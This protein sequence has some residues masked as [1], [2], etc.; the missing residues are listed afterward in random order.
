MVGRSRDRHRLRGAHRKAL[1][2]DLTKIGLAFVA[3]TDCSVPSVNVE[4]GC[5]DGTDPV[6]ALPALR[7][8]PRGR[9]YYR[10]GCQDRRRR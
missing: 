2:P 7:G 3:A 5:P 4:E 8:V 6:Y 9:D 1:R 10:S